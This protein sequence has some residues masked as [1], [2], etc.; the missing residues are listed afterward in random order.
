MRNDTNRLERIAYLAYFCFETHEELGGGGSSVIFKLIN[1]ATGKILWTQL[2][3][4]ILDGFIRQQNMSITEAAVYTAKWLCAAG[5]GNFD[6]EDLD[7]LRL[8]CSRYEH[9][10]ANVTSLEELYSRRRLR[11]IRLLWL[12]HAHDVSAHSRVTE[13]FF[14]GD[15]ICIGR[16]TDAPIYGS[17]PEHVVPCAYIRDLILERFLA[18]PLVIENIED[19]QCA[20]DMCKLTQRLMTVAYISQEH[21]EFLDKGDKAMKIS[22]PAGWDPDIGDVLDRLRHFPGFTNL[23]P[24]T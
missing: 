19:D 9:S 5:A 18:R 13:L 16:S 24:V 7:K 23:I 21:R 17:H 14:A 2:R 20:M 11:L 12:I 15:E 1:P 8:I 4:V 10:F 6:A 3:S 22:M